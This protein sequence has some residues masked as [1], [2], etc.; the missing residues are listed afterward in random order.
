MCDFEKLEEVRF[1]LSLEK[2]TWDKISLVKVVYKDGRTYEVFKKFWADSIFLALKRKQMQ[3]KFSCVY[4]CKRGKFYKKV[5]YPYF[6]IEGYCKECANPIVG[7]CHEKPNPDK[8]DCVYIE[9]ETGL[10]QRK[11]TKTRPLTGERRKEAMSLLK[12]MTVKQFKDQF[13]VQALTDSGS[14]QIDVLYDSYIYKTCRQK[15][16]NLELGLDKFRGK[17]VDSCAAIQLTF[18]TTIRQLST[19]PFNIQYWTENQIQLYTEAL[20][21]NI[22]ITIDASGRFVF[23]VMTHETHGTSY[24]F[25][26]VIVMR[27]GGKIYPI[28]QMLSE[29]QDV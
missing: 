3:Q 27:L 12:Y 8:D 24:I 17:P 4:V 26:Y 23:R 1:L 9:I 25:L 10:C 14:S 11:H 21:Y 19:V 15:A 16:I 28:C 13:A 7:I 22:P 18:T 20:E 2:Q 5:N 29:R 6:V